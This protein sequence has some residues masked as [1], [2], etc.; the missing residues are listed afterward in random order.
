MVRREDV[1]ASVCAVARCFHLF[2]CKTQETAMRNI[3]VEVLLADPS[4][5]A[6]TERDFEVGGFRLT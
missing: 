4:D 2:S 5:A 3:R 6:L 1:F